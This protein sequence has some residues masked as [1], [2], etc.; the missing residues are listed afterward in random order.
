ME[1]AKKGSLVGLLL[2]HPS[3]GKP[4]EAKGPADHKAALNQAATEM[5]E[6]MGR[7]DAAAVAAAFDN[8]FRIC[9][10]APHDEAGAED[11]ED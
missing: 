11:E 3:P 10:M 5:I 7:K 4:D 2:G 6:A 9:E 8:A 1:S